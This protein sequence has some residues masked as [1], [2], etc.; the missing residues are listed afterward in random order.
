MKKAL[1]ILREKWNHSDF[2]PLQKEIIEAVLAKKN[3]IALLPTGGGKSLCY[4][5][6]ALL[7]EGICL[8][9]SPL[10][11]LMRDQIENLEK[12]NIKATSLDSSLSEK[13]MILLFDNLQ[14][15]NCKFLY[16][17]PEKLQSDLVQ[18]KIKQLKVSLIAVDEAHCISEW[19]HDFRPAYTKLTVLKELCPEANT[20]AL[21]ATATRPV[22][23]DLNQMNLLEEALVFKKSYFREKLAYQ[24]FDVEDKRYKIKQILTKINAP[25]ILYTSTRMQTEKWSQYLNREGFSST[26]YH[27]GMTNVDKSKAYDAWFHEQKKIM[28]ATNAFGMG[29]DKPNLRVVVHLDFPNSLENYLQE[30]GRAGRDGRNAFAVLLKNENDVQRFQE[31]L[32]NQRLSVAFI[33]K[34]YQQLNQ[35]FYIGK[36]ELKKDIAAFDLDLFCQRY[37]LQRG[38]ALSAIK[39]LALEGILVFSEKNKKKSRLKFIAS[40]EQVLK[41]AVRHPSAD[42]LIKT[43]L[44]NQGGLFENFTSICE[45]TLSKKS[46]LSKKEIVSGIEKLQK[47]NLLSY[48]PSNNESTL[49][50]LVP[51]EDEK[52]INAVSKNMV[53]RQANKDAKAL[54]F[55]EYVNNNKICR[56]K[57]LLD[58]FEEKRSSNCGICDVCIGK[59][60]NQ[61]KEVERL[62]KVIL[63]LL[64]KRELSS[65][66][67]V[68]HVDEDEQMLLKTLRLLL[69]EKNVKLTGHN[70][71]LRQV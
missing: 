31:R 69:E 46:S 34:V 1:D 45:Y 43:L 9:V 33:K 40:S 57:Q 15:S 6:P 71:Y 4:Q 63:T 27:G 54:K 50:F 24:I 62:K 21:T 7:Q 47:A 36:G 29:I 56:S 49:L 5:I 48:Q 20:L 60:K 42:P 52:T 14:H 37:Q 38:L 23:E 25:A 12:K 59:K 44:R 10:L 61:K 17:S 35:Y 39:T 16:V 11:A 18:Q 65:R 26:F 41:Y 68:Q 19:G 22:L 30:A 13:E 55:L 2:R 8:V 67:L 51:R 64:E 28:V 32:K 66:E 53:K 3:C 58:Y 70:T